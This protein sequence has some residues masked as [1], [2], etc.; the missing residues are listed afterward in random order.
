MRHCLPKL[1]CLLGLLL[2]AAGSG[3][4]SGDN[5]FRKLAGKGGKQPADSVAAAAA[6][7]AGRRAQ[8][9]R[10]ANPPGERPAATDPYQ[11][12]LDANLMEPAVPA[13]QKDAV[14]EHMNAVAQSLA[15]TG[16][17]RIETMRSREVV[18]ATVGT[19]LLFKPNDTV[20]RATAADVL[21]PYR[22]L[23]QKGLYKIVLACHT[24]DTGSTLYTDRL[25][26]A[27]AAAVEA[28]LAAG[29]AGAGYAGDAVVLPYA[30]G[31]AEPLN[32]N[33]SQ[34]HRAANRRLEIFLVPNRRMI[35]LAR[36][37]KLP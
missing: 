37:G 11:M 22:A 8:E 7:A 36:Y 3:V 32:P 35:E 16:V 5:I 6:P 12:S 24:D 29:A 20:L 30:L 2:L 13:K 26:E 28:W 19:D 21:S 25:S 31:A 4:A 9:G 14:K 10:S 17:A 33:D 23:F 18:V 1:T 15:K 27:R 34:A